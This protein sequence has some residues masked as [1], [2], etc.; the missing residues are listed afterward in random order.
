MIANQSLCT[1]RTL[2]VKYWQTYVLRFLVHYARIVVSTLILMST[3]IL[4]ISWSNNISTKIVKLRRAGILLFYFLHLPPQDH[5]IITLTSS[6]FFTTNTAWTLMIF[7]IS[8]Y[9]IMSKK[10]GMKIFLWQTIFR[11]IIYFVFYILVFHLNI[12]DI[13]IHLYSIN[14]TTHI[15][16]YFR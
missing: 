2:T 3:L 8:Q 5:F 12:F 13:I 15:C 16:Q 1:Y 11:V 14:N 4:T 6:N 7:H 9:L 10:F